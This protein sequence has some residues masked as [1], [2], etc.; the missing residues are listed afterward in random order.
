MSPAVASG[1]GHSFPRVEGPRTQEPLL[2][3]TQLMSSHA[4]QVPYGIMDGQKALGLRR[5]FEAA[6]VTP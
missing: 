6:H 5:R 1:C 4:E 3:G 2:G